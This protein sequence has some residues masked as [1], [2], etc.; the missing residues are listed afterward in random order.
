M[1]K[2]DQAINDLASFIRETHL[3]ISAPSDQPK[4]SV[5]P[6]VMISAKEYGTLML[7]GEDAAKYRQIL[8]D[9]G[10]NVGQNVSKKFAEGRTRECVLQSLDMMGTKGDHFDQRLA[11]S[12]A[13]LRSQLIAPPR[14]WQVYLRVC[15]LAA[16]NLPT[17]LGSVTFCLFDENGVSS[18]NRSLASIIDLSTNAD[19]EKVTIKQRI[20][21]RVDTSLGGKVVG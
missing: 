20:K 11:A 1:G 12:C 8:T 6:E 10:L 17:K 18:L 15:G 7:D 3:E 9:I 19:N 2:L 4:Q 13:T 14:R 5:L 21:D 16:E